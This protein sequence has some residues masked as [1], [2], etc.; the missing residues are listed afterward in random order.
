MDGWPF[1]YP[2]QVRWRDTDPFGH[3]NNAVFASYL[4]HARVELWREQLGNGSSAGI[5]F[6]I[7]HLEVDFRR[8]LALDDHVEVG[9]SVGELGGA[10]FEFH[11]RIEVDGKLAATAATMQVC[12]NPET[13]RPQRMPLW[14]RSGLKQLQQ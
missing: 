2:I 10:S 9:I 8:P 3:V 1:A 5:P 4:E 11:Y 7:S 13:G 12:V 6:W 14:M